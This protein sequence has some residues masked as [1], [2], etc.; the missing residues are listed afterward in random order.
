VWLNLV[1]DCN[2]RVWGDAPYHF[3]GF[4]PHYE[5]AVDIIVP[6]PII[7]FSELRLRLQVSANRLRGPCVRAGCEISSVAGGTAKPSDAHAHAVAVARVLRVSSNWFASP[8]PLSGESR[9]GHWK[10]RVISL[11]RVVVVFHTPHLGFSSPSFI[12][13]ISFQTPRPTFCPSNLSLPCTYSEATQVWCY[14]GDSYGNYLT[15]TVNNL[16]LRRPEV[17]TPSSP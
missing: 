11:F 1:E 5:S 10:R 6:L 16:Q 9:R 4:A 13:Q 8:G 15:V 17:S 2:G 12:F 14:A 7:S 3:V